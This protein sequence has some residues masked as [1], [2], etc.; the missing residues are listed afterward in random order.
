[1]PRTAGLLRDPQPL[2]PGL[3]RTDAFHRRPLFAVEP[4]GG[5]DGE[6]AAPVVAS[7]EEALALH[8]P[9]DAEAINP[10]WLAALISGRKTAD[11]APYRRI[12]RLP[13]AHHVAIHADGSRQLAAYDPLAGGAGPLEPE[14]LHA[15]I[16]AGLLS[17]L[18]AALAGWQGPIGCE[19]SSGID[20]NAVLGGLV[21][22]LGVA[23]E[24]IHTWSHEGGGE[25]PLLE[26]FRP[27]YGLRDEQVNGHRPGATAAPE[28]P[29]PPLNPLALLGAPAQI[30]G[31]LPAL[32]A[33]QAA[34]AAVMFS[35]FGGDQ[36][37]SHNAAN[38]ATDLVAQG[39]WRELLAWLEGSPKRAIKTGLGRSLALRSRR[40]IQHRINQRTRLFCRSDLLERHLSAEGRQWLG[41]YLGEDH[42]WEINAYVPLRMSLRQRVLAP[43]VAVRAEEETRLAAAFGLR[44]AF[45]LLDETLIGTLLQQDPMRFGEV[46]GRGRLVARRAFE[47]FLP[48][49]LAG[50]PSKDREGFEA[51]HAAREQALPA[52][53]ADALAALEGSLHPRAAALWHWPAIRREVETLLS[54]P[55]PAKQHLMGTQRALRTLQQVNQWLVWLEEQGR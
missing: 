41:P 52:Q 8:G 45:P 16:R 29:E 5:G 25:G 55:A 18:R 2:G 14:A 39:R 28:A 53:L 17:H 43:W 44:K 7:W 27:F 32:A 23:P 10:A 26:Q 42:P 54:Q 50:N 19:H 48:P 12:V 1:M 51:E 22:G 4:P 24:R 40:F 11:Q 31:M 21:R 37:L 13:R 30:G 49:F 35:G 9:L 33:F 15:L 46:A 38:V 47:P 6:G 3:Y 36:A 20:S 34:G